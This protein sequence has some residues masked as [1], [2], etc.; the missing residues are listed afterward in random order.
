MSTR[1]PAKCVVAEIEHARTLA[2]S[3]VAEHARFFILHYADGAEVGLSP[4]SQ[5]G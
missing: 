1:V 5:F 4:E 2:Y 3:R